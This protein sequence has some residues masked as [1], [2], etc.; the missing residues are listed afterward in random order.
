MQPGGDTN[1]LYSIISGCCSIA[2]LGTVVWCCYEFSRN[3]DFCEISYKRFNEDNESTYPDLTMCLKNKFDEE[4]LRASGNGINGS[5]YDKFLMGQYWD[6]Q[7]KNV[8]FDDVSMKLEDYLLSAKVKGSFWGEYTK[9]ANITKHPLTKNICYTFHLSE[10]SDLVDAEITV[11]NSI[12]ANGMRPPYVEF[13]VKFH[14]PNQIFRAFTSTSYRWADR[15]ATRYGKYYQMRFVINSME[16]FQRREKYSM[17]CYDEKLNY[18]RRV[19]D[20]T[21]GNVGCYPPYYNA[22]HISTPCDSKEKLLQTRKILWEEFT[23]LKNKWP[24]CAEIQK[25][26]LGYHEEDLNASEEDDVNEAGD[27]GWFKVI[28]T[29]KALHFKEI[30]QTRA[31]TVQ[32]LVGNVGGYLGLFLGYSLR[33]IHTLFSAL[34]SWIKTIC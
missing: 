32:S 23:K 20:D 26:T 3:I 16:V 25:L 19:L 1:S 22:S 14:Y 18:D 10:L 2:T 17:P 33:D 11:K 28:V 12:F 7:I 5:L 9:I 24:P 15:N 31:Y 21:V 6:D 30:K 4:K 8:N 34:I 29:N 13:F 27:N